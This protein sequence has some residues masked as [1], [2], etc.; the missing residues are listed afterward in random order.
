VKNKDIHLL[1]DG[2]NLNAT[3]Y[4]SMEKSEAVEKMKED[5]FAEDKG[6]SD[7]WYGKA[8]EKLA[9]ALD[10]GADKEAK[11]AE[12]TER[13]NIAKGKEAQKAAEKAKV[14]TPGITPGLTP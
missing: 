11:Q 14:S 5:G 13:E 4:G 10:K 8:W 7:D 12:K 9:A 3:H 6:L 1:V 2:F